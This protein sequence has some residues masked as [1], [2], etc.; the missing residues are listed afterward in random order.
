M[1]CDP[2]QLKLLPINLLNLCIYQLA[3]Y[4]GYS[5]PNNE[6]GC[7]ECPQLYTCSTNNEEW[8]HLHSELNRRRN[9]E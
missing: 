4:S 9:A 8:F 1:W 6:R 5:C 3:T 7:Q 2:K